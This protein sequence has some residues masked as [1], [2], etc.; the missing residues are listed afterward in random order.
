[1]NRHQGGLGR[2]E[3][4]LICSPPFSTQFGDPAPAY[5]RNQ[6]AGN[7]GHKC[8]LVEIGS[9]LFFFQICIPILTGV[10]FSLAPGGG[11]SCRADKLLSFLAKVPFL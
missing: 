1:M 7:L 6:V 2:R 4:F 5:R 11:G 9:S 10:S 8:K 3:N